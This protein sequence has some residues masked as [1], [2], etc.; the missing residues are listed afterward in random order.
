MGA[1]HQALLT[2]HEPAAGGG[3]PV[4][5]DFNRADDAS[6]IGTSTSGHVWIT[7]IGTM[8]ISS[9]KVYSPSLGA[10][11]GGFTGSIATVE[12]NE[13]DVTI[14][15]VQS[16]ARTQVTKCG[17]CFRYVDNNNF[18]VARYM[19][20]NLEI[21]IYKMLAG[22]YG[23]IGSFPWSLTD[24]H[25]GQVMQ[26]ELLGSS[27]KMYI[28]GGPPKISTTDTDLQTATR[29][30]IHINQTATRQDDLSIVAT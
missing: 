23:S 19:W 4:T 29:H 27:I 22:V 16:T 25:D 24:S 13:P 7:H 15:I 28:D 1:I 10:G 11:S 6:F 20:Q 12:T 18:Y 3:L 8:G 5:D 9:N 26:V 30:G 14:E 2:F 21:N 17:L